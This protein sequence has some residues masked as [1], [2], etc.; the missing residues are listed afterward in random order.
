MPSTGTHP[1]EDCPE[2]KDQK[3]Q[4]KARERSTPDVSD[5][6][7]LG[8]CSSLYKVWA[9]CVERERGQAKACTA[10]LK[11]F[12]ECHSANIVANIRR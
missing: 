2:C 11:D 7:Q 10:V 4:A 9:D 8:D 12:K 6:L 5:G 1:E 3:E